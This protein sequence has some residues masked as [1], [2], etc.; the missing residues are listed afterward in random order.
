MFGLAQY[1]GVPMSDK[2]GTVWTNKNRYN[3]YYV[4]DNYKHPDLPELESLPF[5][6]ICHNVLEEAKN[7]KLY[8]VLKEN[9][10]LEDL[11]LHNLIHHSAAEGLVN[12][13]TY[14]EDKE[15]YYRACFSCKEG[16]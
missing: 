7:G 15:R 6:N 3:L 8:S 12:E 2:D 14:D 11:K 1:Y 13:P 4:P 10:F 5:G 16:Q 9:K